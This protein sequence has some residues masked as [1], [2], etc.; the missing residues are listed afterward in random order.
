[1]RRRFEH[2]LGDPEH[3]PL[4]VAVAS[5]GAI[6]GYGRTFHLQRPR[7]ASSAAAA[8]PS[9]WYLGGLL[10]ARDHRRRGIGRALTEA[11]LDHIFA[12]ADAAFYFTNARNA[13]SLALHEQLGFV[14]LTRDFSF[15]GVTFESGDGVLSRVSRPAA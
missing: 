1:M 3:R 2:D 14:E 9:G 10:T 12:R 11:R 5:G 13:A 4:F 7:E 15:P 6:V 8:P